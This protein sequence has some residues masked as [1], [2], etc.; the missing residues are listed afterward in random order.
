[1]SRKAVVFVAE[2]SYMEKLE[3]AIK[4]LCA[5]HRHLKIYVLNENIPTEWFQ[6]MNHRL[7]TIDSEILNCRVAAESFKQFS[8]P[9][10]H[11]HY[12][13]FFRYCIPELV[14]EDRVLYLDCDMIVTKSLSD[15]F[16][17]DLDGCG[18]GAVE[19]RPTTREGFNAGLLVLDLAW[20][21]DHQTT[22]ALFDLTKEHHQHVYGDQGILNHYFKDAWLR[23][24]LTYNLQVGSDKDQHQYGDLAWYDEFQG[25]PAVIH[26]TSHNKPWTANRFN[27]FREIWWFYYA[28]SW[29]DNLLRKPLMQQRLEDLVGE[30][31]YHTAVYTHSAD[32][33]EVE[34]LLKAFP[35]VA[36]HVLAHTH[37]GFGLIQLERYPNLILYP[38]FDPLTS[39]KV[40]EKIDFYLD[41]N[42]YGEVDQITQKIHQLG[43][44][45][46]SFVSTNHDQT[47]QNHLFEDQ[48]VDQMIEAIRQYLKT[49]EK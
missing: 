27:R 28:L 7:A 33:H 35:D 25:L 37:F 42:P 1:M 2:L 10:S 15:L 6:L 11:L 23:L 48:Q 8:L 13:T 31:P 3:I 44:P 40:L 5:H 21:R 12:A 36:F 19:D 17:V 26:Y 32:L 39:H 30:F 29:E 9:S 4:S 41:I 49:V 14:E 38:A 47:G 46:Y 20:W 22:Q 24:P 43:K 16:E 18:L 34:L 45:I